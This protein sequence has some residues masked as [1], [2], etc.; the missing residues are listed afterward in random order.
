MI[1]VRQVK[2]N[3]EKNSE[4]EIKR[5]LLKKLK[6]KSEEV[7]NIKITKQSIDAREKPILYFVYELEVQ[8]KNEQA[9]LNKNKSKD[10]FKEEKENFQLKETKEKKRKLNHRPI[11]VGSGPA[12]LFCAYILAYYGYNPIILER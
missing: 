3:V 6:A 12:G 1:K 5:Q 2:V 7:L 4:E 9:Y 8:L 11:V 10:I